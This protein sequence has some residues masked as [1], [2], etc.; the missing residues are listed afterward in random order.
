MIRVNKGM[1][2]TTAWQMIEDCVNT[3][4]NGC[5][6]F[7][8]GDFNHDLSAEDIEQIRKALMSYDVLMEDPTDNV[9]KDELFEINLSTVCCPE[10]GY[11]DIY[12][13]G[14]DPKAYAIFI[15]CQHKDG[16]LSISRKEV[17]ELYSSS[18][19]ITPFTFDTWRDTMWMLSEL[20]CITGVSYDGERVQARIKTEYLPAVG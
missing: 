10:Q 15:A 2:L 13:L 14:S 9:G 19:E 6:A 16:V 17:E 5:E 3:C 18:N 20:P 11:E 4:D 12:V 7:Y 8:K 1:M